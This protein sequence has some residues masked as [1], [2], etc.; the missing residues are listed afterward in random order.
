MDRLGIIGVGQMGRGIAQI[1]AQAGLT[2]QLLDQS[3]E[4]AQAGKAQITAVLQKL[5]ERGK[6]DAEACA[7][8][9]ERLI[10]VGTPADLAPCSFVIEAASED[11][12][13]KA[14][15]FHAVSPHLS[16]DAILASN[17]SSISI[18]KLARH[19]DRPDR[20]IGLHFFNPVPLMALVE[21]IQGLGTSAATLARAQTLAHQLGKTAII[22]QDRSAP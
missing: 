19:S 13:L 12:A 15:L 4:H 18:T 16:P 22:A 20:F 21:I 14:K 11:L 10:A 2:V 7:Q 8:T 6:L 9:L 3:L 5:V 1:A 17:T